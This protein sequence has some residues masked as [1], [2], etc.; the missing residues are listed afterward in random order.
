[1]IEIEDRRRRMSMTGRYT[2]RSFD[3]AVLVLFLYPF[4]FIYAS[5]VIPGF[6]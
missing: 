6:L 4:H 5:F 3:T 1:M 2:M